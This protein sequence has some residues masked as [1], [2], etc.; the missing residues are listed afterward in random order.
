MEV[1]R[2]Q[3]K[4]YQPYG[5]SYWRG[6]TQRKVQRERE[7]SEGREEPP[8]VPVEGQITVEEGSSQ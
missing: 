3:I 5:E 8:G 4:G 6:Q 1:I 7:D 2:S